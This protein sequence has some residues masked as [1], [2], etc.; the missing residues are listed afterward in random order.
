MIFTVTPTTAFEFG[1]KS[2][3]LEMYLQ[4]IYT[5]SVNLAGLPAISL[6]IGFDS[7]KMPIGA[8]FIG[9]AYGEQVLFDGALS[10]ENILN[11]GET[12]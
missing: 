5:I 9:Q 1:S 10:I 8:Q 4:D 11:K 3:P 6:P 7:K 2:D 12:V